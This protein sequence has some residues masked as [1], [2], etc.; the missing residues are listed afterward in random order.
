MVAI[1]K[2][3]YLLPL[4]LL[5]AFF[6][7]RAV[8]FAP[9]DFANYYF[10]GQFMAAGQFG[11]WIYLPYEFNNAITIEGYRGIFGSYAPNTP[12]LAMVFIP[13]SFFELGAAKLIF[14]ILSIL[15]FVFTLRRLVRQYAI[16]PRYLLLIPIVC[17]TPIK[18]SILFGQVYFLLFFL[19][20][21]SWLAYKK[22]RPVSAAVLLAA[23][24]CLKVFP[25][26]LTLL[27]VFR[28]KYTLLAYLLASCIGFLLMS[29]FLSSAEV[30]WF[31]F[32]EVLPRASSGE[33]STGFVPNYQSVLM[34]LKQ[35]LV[36][37]AIENPLAAVDYPELLPPL[38]IALKVALVTIG[39]DVSRKI[40]LPLV[41][42]SYWILVL[43]LMS[44]Y[45]S[46]YSLVLLLIPFLALAASHLKPWQKA[47]G[48]GLIFMVS[49]IPMAW[50]AHL[51][52]PFTY[53]RLLT[54]LLL[55]ALF[56]TLV[57]KRVK[58]GRVAVLTAVPMAVVWM[59]GLLYPEKTLQS[60]PLVMRSPILIYDYAI[61]NGQLTYRSW[62][63]NGKTRYSMAIDAGKTEPLVLHENTIFLDGKP[64][65]TEHGNK[66]KPILV[67]GRAIIYLSDHG[68][69]IGFYTLRRID[70]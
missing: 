58:F 57:Y 38:L 40:N 5:C 51:P 41:V 18:N 22:K 55:L 3:Y 70:L 17:F 32:Q 25:L 21:E 2:K 65:A 34:F 36:F 52:Y 29:M 44:P 46:T 69:G 31:V 60:R 23:A 43:L 7:I 37:D 24:I 10:G 35:L 47:L 39:Y 6:T 64:L 8:D 16:D 56:M 63:T 59:F 13:F 19:I 45:G 33:I 20:G 9:H 49:N 1:D 28:K 67:D 27:F 66:K 53:F 14:N 62:D 15:L 61:Q 50:F 68:R 48:L 4:L 26:L 12:F 42:L 11:R 30:W 54:M